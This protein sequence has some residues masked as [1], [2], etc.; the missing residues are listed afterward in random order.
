MPCATIQQ[1]MASR[2]R[3]VRGAESP[4]R[5][6]TNGHPVSVNKPLY[7][8]SVNGSAVVDCQGNGHAFAIGL[9]E[10]A[11]L[12]GFTVRNASKQA[13]Y[14]Y[15]SYLEVLGCVLEDNAVWANVSDCLFQRNAG[16]SVMINPAFASP[17]EFVF[18]G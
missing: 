15:S 1:G 13:I 12:V 9:V 6:L 17:L 4:H 3:S 11:V 8:V 7:V 5:Y 10:Y 18:A 16:L 2:G 14:A